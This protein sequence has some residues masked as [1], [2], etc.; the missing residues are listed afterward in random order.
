MDSP[1]PVSLAEADLFGETS[2]PPAVMALFDDGFAPDAPD[3]SGSASLSPSPA[4][5]GL[6]DD[7]MQEG[8]ELFYD[9]TGMDGM[10]MDAC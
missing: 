2:G 5:A 1:V 7:P 8:G 9:T 3:T 4:F 10:E 6:D